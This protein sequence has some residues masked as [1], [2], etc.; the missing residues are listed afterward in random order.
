MNKK[1]NDRDGKGRLVFSDDFN[2]EETDDTREELGKDW[3]TNSLK[4]AKGIKQADLKDNQLHLFKIKEANHAVSARHN[5]PFKNGFVEVKFMITDK[6]GINFNFNDPSIKDLAWA[7]HVCQ[8]KITPNDQKEGVF[9]MSTHIKRKAGA[10]K[11]EVNK[12]I[13]GTI[14]KVKNETLFNT[15]YAI[16]IQFT[17]HILTLYIHGKE[18]GLHTSSGFAN[19]K[20]NIAFVVDSYAIIDDLVVYS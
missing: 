4:R 1:L 9:K 6:K 20:Q 16:K 13:K 18:I 5:A 14:N 10:S 17:E 19:I 8:V 2:R 3:V 11:E 7:G 15:W 12:L